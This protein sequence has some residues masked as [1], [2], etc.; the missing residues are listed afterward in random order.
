ML[1][2]PASDLPLHTRDWVG[3]SGSL[4]GTDPQIRAKRHSRLK[5]Q[6]KLNF[7]VTSITNQKELGRGILFSPSIMYLL[8]VC[9]RDFTG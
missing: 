2:A 5:A 1:E 4:A 8:K 7:L 9:R 3:M 6:P